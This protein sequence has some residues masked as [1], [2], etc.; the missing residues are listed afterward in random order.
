MG[1]AAN[2]YVVI[3]DGTANEEYARVGS[4]SAAAGRL[5]LASAT[6]L[7]FPHPAGATVQEVALVYR[8]EGSYYTLDPVAGTVTIPGAPAA[9][10]AFILSYRTDARFGWKRKLGD[11]L[12][13]FFFANLSDDP[14]LDESAG[15]WRGRPVVDG[16]YTVG[17][18]GYRAGEH[19]SGSAGAWEWQTYRSATRSSRFDFLY[20]GSA[21]SLAPYAKID[22]GARCDVCH[23]DLAYHGAGRRGADTCLLCHA[24]PGPAVAGRTLFHGAHAATFPVMPNGAGDCA[25]CHG[26]TD[27]SQPVSRRHP[28]PQSRPTADWTVAC[29]GCHTSPAA[30]AHAETNTGVTSGLEGCAT[31]H[32][33]GR[34]QAVEGVHRAR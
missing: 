24:T 25:A 9:G 31:C 7:R 18:W 2:D 32:A 22:D 28:A 14:A 21:T 12:A 29:T 1:L 5:A 27:V 16:T 34:G 17:A 15:D 4:I 8:Q 11:T 6:P 23:L 10:N 3:D 30:V 26:A 33:P 19:R 20:G 13:P